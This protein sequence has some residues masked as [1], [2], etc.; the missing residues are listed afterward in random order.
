MQTLHTPQA[1]ILY[2]FGVLQQI[3]IGDCI[4]MKFGS[5]LVEI[6][7]VKIVKTNPQLFVLSVKFSNTRSRYWNKE[8]YDS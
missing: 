4:G 6:A 2:T 3:N 5:L 8:L 7:P 1:W